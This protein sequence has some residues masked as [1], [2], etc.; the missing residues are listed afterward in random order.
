MGVRWGVCGDQDFGARK[1]V[2]GMPRGSAQ[3]EEGS[4]EVGR[5]G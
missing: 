2:K 5:K 3:S 1:R 4:E